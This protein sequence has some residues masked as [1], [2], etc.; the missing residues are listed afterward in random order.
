MDFVHPQL[1]HVLRHERDSIL[2]KREE[3]ITN[4][5]SGMGRSGGKSI[6]RKP[7]WVARLLRLPLF[8]W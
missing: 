8:G 6:W 5:S 3:Q 4:Q 2:T 7:T 1:S